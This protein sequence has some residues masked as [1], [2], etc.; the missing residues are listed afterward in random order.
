MS[1]PLSDLARTIHADLRG[2]GSIEI[3]GCATLTEAGPGDLSFLANSKYV[4]QVTTTGASAVVVSPADAEKLGESKALLVADDP[5]FAFREA[6]VKLIGFRKHP[7]AGVHETAIVAST[8]KLGEGCS[9]GAYA[10]IADNVTIGART[11]IYPHVYLGDGATVGDDCILYPGVC[12]YDQCVLGQRVILQ[13]GC[14]IG[15]DGFGYATH[16]G[17]H[18]KIPPAGNAVVE[19]DVEMGSHCSVDRATMGST[20][21]GKGTKFSNG[22]V[23]GH[24]CKIG[25][26]NL[27][28]A[29]VGL[30]G[31]VDTGDYVVFGGKVGVAGHIRIG[32]RV[33][34]AAMTGI[35]RD[36]PDDATIGGAPSADLADARRIWLHTAKLPDLADRVR[37]LERQL[38]KL[39][40]DDQPTTD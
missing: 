20:V 40:A 28:V 33:K 26:Y 22:V 9:V 39:K 30:A 17:E 1:L 24:G 35:F 14:S 32:H 12:V 19:D 3:T 31:S 2:D 36:I 10:V 5:Y 23:I 25:K 15:H 27:Y 16:K 11:V 4:D 7:P 37:R 13:A 34:A 29:Q 8:A 38:E 18:H 6:M 21:I